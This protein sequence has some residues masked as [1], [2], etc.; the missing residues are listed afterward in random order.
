MARR[1][2]LEP[3]T[4][5]F[6]AWCSREP[7]N[8]PASPWRVP[9]GGGSS[10]LLR[11][12]A[13]PR[14]GIHQASRQVARSRPDFWGISVVGSN[15]TTPTRILSRFGTLLASSLD[16]V[17]W[18]VPWW[19]RAVAPECILR[20]RARLATV[21]CVETGGSEDSA[22]EGAAPADR[23][24]AH[25]PGL[26]PSRQPRLLGRKCFRLFVTRDTHAKGTRLNSLQQA[27]R[28]VVVD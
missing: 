26:N 23:R 11:I 7:D 18:L 13:A 2:G 17:L 16:L 5:R 24:I 14:I 1:E 28:V 21:E 15:P 6:E 4:L 9:A 25:R 22:S 12:A 3:P 20:R 8:P 27:G 19:S 10:R